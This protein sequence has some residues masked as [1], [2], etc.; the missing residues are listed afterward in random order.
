MMVFNRFCVH[1]SSFTFMMLWLGVSR[2]VMFNVSFWLAMINSIVADVQWGRMNFCL[3]C[4]PINSSNAFVNSDFPAPVS[5]EIIVS[6]F[7]S[8]SSQ[9]S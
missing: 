5:P 4:C 8:S 6:P 2:L 3:A 9:S 1:S 7:S